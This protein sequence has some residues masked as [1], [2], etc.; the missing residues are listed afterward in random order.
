MVITLLVL[1]V[2]AVLALALVGLTETHDR[3]KHLFNELDSEKLN[4]NGSIPLMATTS[5]QAAYNEQFPELS[6]TRS[7]LA[8]STVRSQ[9]PGGFPTPSPAE[10]S[11]LVLA[12]HIQSKNPDQVV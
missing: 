2:S 3:V 9:D 7:L 4:E 1:S 12:H 10:S 8:L 6:F 5:N 11:S